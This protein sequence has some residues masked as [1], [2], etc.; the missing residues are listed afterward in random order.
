[1]LALP[2][3]QAPHY[4]MLSGRD[5]LEACAR[6][7]RHV[8]ASCTARPPVTPAILAAAAQARAARRAA[9]TGG[10]V[11]APPF[12]GMRPVSYFVAASLDGYIARIDGA[13]DWLF[14]DQASLCACIVCADQRVGWWCKPCH[15]LLS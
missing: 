2:A 4:H 6:L 3:H 5:E 1:M 14:T 11:A 12:L 8:R 9:A 7:L 10:S 15:A 13:V